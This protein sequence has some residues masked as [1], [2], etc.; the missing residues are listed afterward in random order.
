ME[1][2]KRKPFQNIVFIF[3]IR[4]IDFRFFVGLLGFVV[5]A[6]YIYKVNNGVKFENIEKKLITR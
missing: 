5:V 6:Y 1:Y 2:L 3:M 4:S